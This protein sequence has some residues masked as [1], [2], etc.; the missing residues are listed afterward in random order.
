MG[1]PHNPRRYGETWDPE[2]VAALAKEIEAIQGYVIVS[3]GWAWHYMTPPH[4]ELKHAHDH[5]DA[6]LFVT[7]E[8]VPA[9]MTLLRERGYERVW[10]RFDGQSDD[11]HRYVQ[12]ME[13]TTPIKVILDLF[14]GDVP[15]A[16]TVSG[17]RV[18][19][20]RQLLSLYG[21]KHSSGQCF[22]VQIATRLLAAGIN[23]VGHAEMADYSEFLG[24]AR[25]KR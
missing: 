7:P 20:P 23:P 13:G 22:A 8:N 14:T 10:T 4:P 25:G 12:M 17:V 9:L 1:A 24:K 21:V 11:F 19:E 15:F 16:E 6:D 2:H 5:K 3:G 18:V